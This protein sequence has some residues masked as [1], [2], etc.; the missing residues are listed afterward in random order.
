MPG[1]YF[2]PF[3]E[4]YS[5]YAAETGKNCGRWPLGHR[6]ILPDGR[7]YRFAL[8]DGTVEVAGNLYQSIAP[9]TTHAECVVSTVPAIGD[10][11][12]AATLGATLAAVDIYSEGI[13]HTNKVTG[14]GYAYRIKRAVSAEAAHAAVD[15]SGIITVNLA[16]G[17]KV[18]VAGAAT[19][20]VT[21]TRNRFHS[22]II[23]PSPPTAMLAGVSPGVCA[24]SRYYWQQVH[25]EAAVLAD[26]TLL[27]GNMVQASITVDG[28]VEGQK[29][30][31]TAGSTAAADITAFVAL[32]DQDGA[33]VALEVGT[34]AVN[35]VN[36]I[37]GPIAGR[38]PLVGICTKVNITGEYALIDLLHLGV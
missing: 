26:G 9:V 34:I 37:T 23:H 24:A 20:E 30:R 28:A 7:I 36:D 16:P 35:A 29:N 25:G 14:L 38:A 10:T 15:A 18:Q 8:N 5:T 4:Q 12:I 32:E 21:F 11:T 33:E 17:E 2:G 3:N 19:T 27:V 31:V 1:T 6:L 13:V 22:T